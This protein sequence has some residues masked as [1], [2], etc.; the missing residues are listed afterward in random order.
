VTDYKA[1]GRKWLR[2]GEDGRPYIC[3][4]SSLDDFFAGY[5]ALEI[6]TDRLRE[7]IA[8]RQE[9]GAA[10]GTV[11]RSLALLRRMFKLAVQDQK[12]R[13]IPYFPMLKEA[14]PRKGFLEHAEF[15]KPRSELPE[16]L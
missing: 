4:I 14:A 12:L 9:Q 2:T 10:N 1:N 16:H 7:F 5:R 6:T 11:N 15:Q 13:D 3:G 8:K